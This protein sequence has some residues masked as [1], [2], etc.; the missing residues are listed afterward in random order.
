MNEQDI[1]ERLNFYYEN[2]DWDNFKNEIDLTNN[3][4][5]DKY[6]ILHE[7]IYDFVPVEIVEI[8]LNKGA[9]PNISNV[10]NKT[11][12]FYL[13]NNTKNSFEKF[14]LFIDFNA[15]LNFIDF[16]EDNFLMN[17]FEENIF[18]YVKE[19][20]F[21][22]Y[23]KN[24]FN[25]NIFH[26]IALRDVELN[27]IEKYNFL[28]IE[29]LDTINNGG[30]TPLHIATIQLN[31]VLIKQLINLGFDKEKKTLKVSESSHSD[32]NV[33][34]PESLNMKQILDFYLDNPHIL[35]PENDENYTKYVT[36]DI[37]KNLVMECIYNL[38][39]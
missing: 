13:T 24:D 8:A 18:L 31:S 2:K 39:H 6:K 15:N 17:D 5:I 14:K 20:G 35:L 21:D 19:K 30:L 26:N 33:Q 27:Q 25:N 22:Y 23:H 32:S 4:F 29:E 7:L 1:L 38:N 9:N 3:L 16:Y 34:I 28:K 36:I 37:M 12:I 11:P 10:K